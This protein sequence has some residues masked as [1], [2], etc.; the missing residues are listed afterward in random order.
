LVLFRTF[1]VMLLVLFLIRAVWRL[2]AGVV[3]GA[4]GT[5]GGS[6]SNRPASPPAVKM[7]RDPVC[8]TYVVPGKAL[9]LARGRETL[10]FCS[11]KCRDQYF[12][13]RPT[14]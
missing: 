8:G 10:Y 6:Q 4:S 1:L 12:D 13:K 9:E 2:L 11:E 3:Q 14:S 7:V 5:A